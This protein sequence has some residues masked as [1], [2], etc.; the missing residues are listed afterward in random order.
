MRHFFTTAGRLRRRAY[1]GRVL[2]LYLLAFACYSLPDVAAIQ[3]DDT[4][5]H[6]QYVALGGL[7]VTHYLIY[8]QCIKRLHDLDLR[9][10]WLLLFLLP[11]VSLVLGSGMQFVSGTAGPNRF[12]AD[13]R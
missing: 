5:V 9:G 8:A 13:P 12:G 4:A 11:V 2:G 3:F 7:L 10:W 1:F 6:W